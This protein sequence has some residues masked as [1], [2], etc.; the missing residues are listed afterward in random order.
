MKEEFFITP[1]GTKLPL[2]DIRGKLY[3]EAAWRVMWFR[4]ER[5]TWRIETEL[6]SISDKQATLK[7]IVKD[8][9]GNVIASAHRQQT[10]SFQNMVEKAESQAIGRALALV[11]YGTQWALADFDE[12][13]D[14]DLSKLADSPLP[15]AGTVQFDS[16]PENYRVTFG[17]KYKDRTLKEIGLPD[18]ESFINWLTAEAD[19]KNKP[20]GDQVRELVDAVEAWKGVLNAQGVFETDVR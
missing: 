19:K 15:R 13:H 10:N 12:G 11:G 14:D 5:P 7:A 6:I 17:K 4:E 2:R 1:K 8:E 3:L 20:I 9:Q 18:I 16:N